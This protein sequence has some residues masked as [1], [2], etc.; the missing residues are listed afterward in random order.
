MVVL[1]R[2]WLPLLL[3][4]CSL[5]ACEE[6]PEPTLPKE[7]PTPAVSMLER[8][9]FQTKTTRLR[10]RETPDLEGAV[11]E[12]LP[13]GSLVEYLHDST[14]FTTAITYNQT[15]YDVSWYK[16]KTDAAME[17]W[18]YSAFVQPL[19]ETQNQQIITQREAAALAEAENQEQ[20]KQ[21]A[22]P[23]EEE[24]QEQL[25]EGLLRAY[26]ATLEQLSTQDPK[27]VGQAIN[28]YKSLLINGAS[29]PTHDAAYVAFRQ[30]YNRVLQQLRQ[31]YQGQFQHLAPELKRYERIPMN[32]QPMLVLLGENGFNFGFDNNRVVLAEDTDWIFRT[33]Y[34]EVSTPMRVYMNQYELEEPNFWYQNDKL[35]ITPTQLARWIL[36]WN[37]F[38]ATYPDF[39]WHDDA[40]RRLTIQLDLLLEGTGQQPAFGAD[41]TLA[42]TYQDAYTYIA[43]NYPNSNIG[44]AFQ[45]YVDALVDNN[46][47]LNATVRNAQKQLRNTLL[48]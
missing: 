16:I 17:G 47:R 1:L 45:R 5:S 21:L 32:S 13:E 10:V 18:V 31:R 24:Q 20:A 44:K 33:F 42:R 48:K 4:F 27:A 43:N 29:K 3:I 12:I 23:T 26:K 39:V 14:T 34:R 25:N 9:F 41:Q 2:A 11:L 37:Y 30:W 35:L 7:E 19:S 28:R 36:S 6:T 40:L 22:L 8:R 15:S 38:V 46:Q